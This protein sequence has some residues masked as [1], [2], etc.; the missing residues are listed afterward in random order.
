MP[1]PGRF[2]STRVRSFTPEELRRFLKA[3]DAR[4][5][6]RVEMIVL[7]GGALAVAWDVDLG[8]SDI[9]TWTSV[10]PPLRRAVDHARKDTGLRVPV[11]HASV[12]DAPYHFE[13]RLLRVLP[14]LRRL[15]VFVPDPYDVALS[16]T[17]RGYQKDID[18]IAALHGRHPLDREVLVGRYLDEMSHVTGDPG[19]IEQNFVLLVD[20]LYGEIEAD[21]VKDLLRDRDAGRRT[22]SRRG[23]RP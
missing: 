6:A 10:P 21:R 9:D 18:A 1:S 12:S 4:L 14:E 8:T 7:G 15:I 17:C 16:K 13:D 22:G 11:F 2:T 3:A 5:S 20:R 23:F 19:R